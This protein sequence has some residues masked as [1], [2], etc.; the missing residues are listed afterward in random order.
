MK[1]LKKI[2]SVHMIGIKGTGMSSLAVNLKRL[3]VNVIGS[4]YPEKFFTDEL[5]EIQKI[6]VLSPFSPKN[7]STKTDLVIVSTAYN[8]KNEEV[9]EAERRGLKI[10]SYAQMLG[11]LSGQLK[12]VAV[13]GSHGKTT[14]SGALSYILSKSK[15]HPIVNVGSIVPQLLGYKPNQ[16][17]LFVFEADEYQNKFEHFHPQ[18]VLLT[19]IDFDHPDYFRDPTHYKRV[20]RNFVQKIPRDGLLV[21]C[22]DD[23]NNREVAKYAKCPKLSYGFSK[24]ADYKVAVQKILPSK[25]EFSLLSNKKAW[26]LTSKLIGKHNALNLSA[27]ALCSWH[28]GVP[29]KQLRSGVANFAGTR[30]RLETMKQLKINGWGCTVIDDFGHHPTEIKNT[31]QTL[32]TAYPDKILWTVF[33]PHTFSRTEALLED[34]S[35]AFD[36]SDKTIILDIY[37]SKRETVGKI[38]SKDLVRK[39]GSK[40][41]LYKPD[42]EEAAKFIKEKINSPSIILTL[43][44]SEVWQ[45]VNLL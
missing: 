36:Q 10:L 42:I 7:L 9:Q 43:G 44:A 45:M 23:K 29:N 32:K 30:R 16:P 3:G 14:T 21:Y 2:K 13:C 18:I 8:N 28:L 11:L 19:N 27:S 39:T 35:R 24:Y 38:H 20:F 37:A 17:K 5:L 40:N 6:K 31:I 41:V 34:F 25:M 4:D 12:S 22:A 15:Y 33:Q 1:A 26:Q